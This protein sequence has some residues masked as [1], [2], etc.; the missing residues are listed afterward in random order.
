M[1]VAIILNGP[2]GVG[3][4]TL[5]D[6]ICKRHDYKHANADAFKHM[7]SPKRSK[8][9]TD[10]GEKL[11]YIYAKELAVR[12]FSMVIEAVPDK[13]LK[14]IRQLLRKH[15]YKLIE[16]SLV[17]PVEQCIKNDRTR[18]VY[19]YGESAIR[20]VYPRFLVRKG[21]VIDVTNKSKMEVL[22]LADKYI[23]KSVR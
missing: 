4:S 18:G 10:I 16:I 1:P 19:G 6:M 3:K 11:G 17:A 9:R 2:S 13:Y 8:I 14:R 22:R 15:K 5:A 20:E 7:F 12:E 23:K 21:F